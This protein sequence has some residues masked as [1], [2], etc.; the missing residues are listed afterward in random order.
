MKMINLN[1]NS[2]LEEVQRKISYWFNNIDLLLQAFTR[3][4]YSAQY[5]GEN[6]EVLEFLGDKVLDMYV[7]KVIADRFGFMK[8]QSEYYD[9]DEDNN[10]YCIIAHKNEGDFTELRK[11]IVNNKTL[12]KRIDKLGFAKYMYL[13]DSDLDNNVV[14]QEKVKADLFEAILGAIAIDCDWNQDDLQNSVEFMLKID[15]FLEDVDTKEERPTKFKE[16][17]AVN[18][19]KEMAE[20]GR[21]SI[22]EYYQSDEQVEIKDGTLMW[23]CTCYI[24]N[25]G[26]QKTAYATSK[27]GAKRYAAYLVLCDYFGLHDEFSEEDED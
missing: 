9:E 12:A 11:E 4:S 7:T 24:R 13:G 19:L 6:N 10:E 14:N 18:T 27:K 22:P 15:D 21:C 17:N 3:S 8:S 20:H 25:W 5:G 16:E 2:N 26:I 1:E 23:E